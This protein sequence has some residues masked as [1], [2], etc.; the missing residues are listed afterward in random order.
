MKELSFLLDQSHQMA[1]RKSKLGE[2]KGATA[3]GFSLR[4]LRFITLK[5]ENGLYIT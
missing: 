2:D 1:S 4:S 5:E 3:G